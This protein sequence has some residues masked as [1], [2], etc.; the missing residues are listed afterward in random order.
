M[1]RFV[2]WL[3]V[4]S[5]ETATFNVW[6]VGSAFFIVACVDGVGKRRN[7][8]K[9]L[10]LNSSLVGIC[11]FNWTKTSNVWEILS[12]FF[13][14]QKYGWIFDYADCG[15]VVRI[16]NQI[17]ISNV[18]EKLGLLSSFFSILYIIE[19][20]W[21]VGK[22]SN[23][24][25]FSLISKLWIFSHF[26]WLLQLPSSLLQVYMDGTS[27]MSTQERKASLGEFYGEFSFSF[28]ETFLPPHIF[29]V[30][31]FEL[32]VHLLLELPL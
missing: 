15:S 9:P 12:A 23:L 5:N 26:V 31:F 19:I 18:W 3:F 21:K 16:S 32:A 2:G 24:F 11:I 29:F 30:T 1:C 20:R 4:Y 17:T 7:V 13:L 27:T 6:E 14:L 25:V 10:N 8:G 28:T 22:Q